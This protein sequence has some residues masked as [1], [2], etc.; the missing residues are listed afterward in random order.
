MKHGFLLVALAAFFLAACAQPPTSAQTAAD[1]PMYN[2]DY[3]STRFS[4]LTEVSAKNVAN[5]RQVCSYVL[6]ETATFESGIVA[7]D[8]T[9]YATTFEYTYAIDAATCALRWK[10]RHQLAE[11]PAVGTARGVAL[12]GNMV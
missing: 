4:A 3:A 8:G 9:L 10:A 2:R 12:S 11:Q 7:A 6:P 1:W 5:L